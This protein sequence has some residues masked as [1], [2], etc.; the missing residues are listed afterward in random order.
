MNNDISG[1][2]AKKFYD[3][4]AL[5]QLQEDDFTTGNKF[6]ISSISLNEIE[7]IKNNRNKS[8]Q[9]RFKAR[10]ISKYLNQYEDKYDVAIVRQEDYIILDKFNLP[11]NNDN[12]LC[13]SCYRYN[14]QV[15]SV[16][17]VSLDSNCKLIASKIFNLLV[18]VPT[19]HTEQDEYVGYKYITLSSDEMCYFYEHLDE[20]KYDC[21][22]NQYIII[23]NTEDGKTDKYKWT[24]EKFIPLKFKPVNHDLV[25]KVKP[26]NSKQELG[27]D[28]LQDSNSTVKVLSGKFG[29]GKT[30]LMVANA[31][32]LIKA[33]KYKKI[34][35]L[36]N[37]IEVKGTKPIGYLPS[38]KGDKL[39]PFC[40]PL[41][42]HV[43][44]EDGLDTLVSSG[45]VEIEH[46]GFMRG[47]NL[48]DTIVILSEA[49]NSS[50]EHISLLLGR[51]GQNSMLWVDGDLQQ[52]DSDMF[53]YKNGLKTVVDRLKGQSLFAYVKLEEC[54]RSETA[55]LADLLN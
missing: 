40:T 29:S 14:R 25:G 21:L 34:L 42:D 48:T 19:K 15:D 28:M 8:D 22:V 1:H 20:N 31:L 43:G 51:I 7:S 32:Q 13:S 18:E 16:V 37:N 55:K 49:E 4:C 10:N 54:E 41:M 46:L 9:I 36:R 11:L 30:Y 33:G 52:I 47:R 38:S 5:L 39:K 3:T 23:E 26:I 53:E 35:W 50:S 24:G 17:F 12:L 27:F 6:V 44:G 2:E 45:Q